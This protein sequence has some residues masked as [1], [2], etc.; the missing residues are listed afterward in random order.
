MPASQSP[1]VGYHD[2]IIYPATVPFII[3]HLA[4]LGAIWTGV[5]W[6]AVG[7]AVALYVARM[8]G[9]TGGYHRYF[10][11]RSFKAGRGMQFVLAFLAQSS[12]QK[13]VL[14]WAA[15]H[16]HHHKFS[17]TEDDI[18]SPRHR[19]F[20][21]SHVAWIFDR[22]NDSTD[23][24]A[25]PD[26]AK[27]PELMFL[28]RYEQVPSIVLGLACYLALGWQGLVVGFIWSTTALFHGTFFINSLAH[29]HGDRR[30]ATGDDSRNNWWLAIITMGEGWHN[31]HHAYQ[32]SARQGF[33]WW[34]VDV[35]Y[36]IL[37][38][39]AAVGLVRDLVGPPADVVRNERALGRAT[40]ER[41]ARQLAAR[42]D[43]DAIEAYFHSLPRFPTR[44]DLEAKLAAAMPHLPHL[45][46]MAELE[47]RL[48]H[49]PTVDELRERALRMIPHTPSL[50]EICERA[51]ELVAQ[52]RAYAHAA[53]M[54][55]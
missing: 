21:Y 25:V 39:L 35:T 10:S 30:Y 20:W 31:N 7:L 34:E 50:D 8:F 51:R 11:H 44:A 13:S 54:P 28:H 3:V 2:D 24:E 46:T 36:Y 15:L 32:R 55:A 19:G 33:R 23:L 49:L 12:A 38:G 16:R 1:D 27:Y 37:R 22:R 45:P 5:S 6:P 52:A 14:W 48:P 4:C 40:I 9:I 43:R 17:D 41:I 29:V 47:A 42:V 53:P 26:L 18:H